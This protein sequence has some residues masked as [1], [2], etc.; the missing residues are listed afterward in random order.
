[1]SNWFSSICC[2]TCNVIWLSIN[3]Q[4]AVKLRNFCVKLSTAL[5]RKS[6]FCFWFSQFSQFLVNF[7]IL[8]KCWYFNFF[9]LPKKFVKSSERHSNLDN[10][11]S[12]KRQLLL[13]LLL[14]DFVNHFVNQRTWREKFTSCVAAEATRLHS[15][16]VAVV[17]VSMCVYA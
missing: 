4:L 14:L 9:S 8:L 17:L 11:G 12:V 7:I 13:F 2:C 6:L 5:D 15:L 1:M 10:V 16:T 3:F